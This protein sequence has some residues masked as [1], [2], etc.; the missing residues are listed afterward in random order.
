MTAALA[1]ELVG[2]TL[3]EPGRWRLQFGPLA[4]GVVDERSG[5]APPVKR[6]VEPSED[7]GRAEETTETELS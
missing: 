1:G 2:F 3:L 6:S 7:P 4:L 5:K